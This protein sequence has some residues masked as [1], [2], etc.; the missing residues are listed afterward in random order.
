MINKD[1][2]FLVE[3]DDLSSEEGILFK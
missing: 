1:E 3:L 2:D